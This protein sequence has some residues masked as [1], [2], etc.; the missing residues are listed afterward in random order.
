[1]S[2]KF[3]FGRT[4]IKKIVQKNQDVGQV[5]A[6]AL[7]AYDKAV[8]LFA[9]HV[10]RATLENLKVEV[11]QDNKKKQKV[12]KEMVIETLNE[13]DLFLYFATLF[14]ENDDD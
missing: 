10:L 6:T 4:R 7:N 3:T 5:R 2:L 8:E 13:E 12:S 14:E 9:A 11:S 1:M